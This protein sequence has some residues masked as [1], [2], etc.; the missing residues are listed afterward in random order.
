ME[1]PTA[2]PLTE[3]ERIFWERPMGEHWGERLTRALQAEYGVNPEWIG[4]YRGERYPWS[5]EDQR[6]L[7]WVKRS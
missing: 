1:R 2:R 5:T 4:P 3:A 7:W 6:W